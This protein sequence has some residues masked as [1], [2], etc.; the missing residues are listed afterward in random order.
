MSDAAKTRKTKSQRL[1]EVRRGPSRWSERS[2]R[3]ALDASSALSAGA[4]APRRTD[5]TRVSFKFQRYMCCFVHVHI[6][7]PA[8]NGRWASLPISRLPPLLCSAALQA[9]AR[10]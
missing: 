10:S 4:A 9:S 7:L 6:G 3:L 8:I 5:G 2:V 1:L